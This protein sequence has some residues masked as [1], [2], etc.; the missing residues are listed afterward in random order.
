MTSGE[1]L[2][3]EHEEKA[4]MARQR[5]LRISEPEGSLE[6]ISSY[7]TTAFYRWSPAESQ[8]HSHVTLDYNPDP[9]LHD[10]L[11]SYS[12]S[13][14]NACCTQLI[15]SKAFAGGRCSISGMIIL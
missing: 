1:N 10:L 11:P 4:R 13:Q 6:I 2:S 14:Y 9:C 5:V 12:D 7:T 3:G 8:V 15:C